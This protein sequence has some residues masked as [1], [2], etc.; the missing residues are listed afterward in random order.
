MKTM[1]CILVFLSGL[2]LVTAGAVTFVQREHPPNEIIV[3]H[4]YKEEFWVTDLE[5]RGLRRAFGAESVPVLIRQAYLDAKSQRWN[6]MPEREKA[7]LSARIAEDAL[8]LRPKLV[9]L[10][11]DA[12]LKYVGPFLRDRGAPVVFAGINGDPNDYG[13]F[14]RSVDITKRGASGNNMTGVL[15]RIPFEAG[16]RLFKEIVGDARELRI[17]TDPELS[18]RVTRDQLLQGA[19]AAG[20]RIRPQHFVEVHE[21]FELQKHVVRANENSS[22]D[23]VI[24]YLP[25]ALDAD[26]LTVVRWFLRNS[27]KPDIGFTQVMGEDGMLCGAFADMELQGY[28]AGLIASLI[29]KGEK[30]PGEIPIY[31]R[32]PK[33]TFINIARAR[34]IGIDRQIP[35]RRLREVD[36]RYSEMRLDPDLIL[37]IPRYR[38][39]RE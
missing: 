27:R 2:T 21:L 32:V 20:I 37:N 15:E 29:L 24:L 34:A 17:F 10:F 6:R 12:A 38:D 19:L 13:I 7:L 14:G 36:L 18:S 8:A 5:I 26:H 4:S 30:L 1:T 39:G 11:D 25:W 28:Y 23:A 9:M 35:F 16:F 31:D 3:I 33:K 22:V